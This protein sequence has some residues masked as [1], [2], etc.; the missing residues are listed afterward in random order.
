MGFPGWPPPTSHLGRVL[1]QEGL[2][3][4]SVSPPV[5]PR[6][7]VLRISVADEAQVQKVKELED[8]EHL[9]VRGS[10]EPSLR[11]Q[12]VSQASWAHL[13]PPR[14][15]GAHWGLGFLSPAAQKGAVGLILVRK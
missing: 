10:G 1:S 5:L 9:Q 8:L 11:P 13:R 7:Q 12:G 2:L 3:G 15:P 14:S 4:P 6:H